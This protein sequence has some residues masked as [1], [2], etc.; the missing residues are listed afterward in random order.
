VLVSPFK[1]VLA[2]CAVAL[3]AACQ[4]PTTQPDTQQIVQSSPNVQVESLQI[5]T[6]ADSGTSDSGAGVPLYYVC[7]VLF[8]NTFGTDL[9]PPIDHFVFSTTGGVIA[10]AIT[11]GTTA[12]VGITNYTGIVKAG[13]KH[14]YTL[15]FRAATGAQGTVY[16]QP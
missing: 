13:E 4:Q 12:T 11:S 6:G 2:L 15:V 10:Q 3:L 14:E 7:K 5:V 9:A 8:T 1:R 16:Y